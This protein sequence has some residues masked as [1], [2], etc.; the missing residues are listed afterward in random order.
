MSEQ[1]QNNRRFDETAAIHVHLGR[2]DGLLT[3]LRVPDHLAYL[4]V[5]WV[6]IINKTTHTTGNRSQEQLHR[7]TTP[8]IKYPSGEFCTPAKASMQA[9]SH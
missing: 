3:P 5:S 2:P 4:L 9:T 6:S 1:S 8:A 7:H